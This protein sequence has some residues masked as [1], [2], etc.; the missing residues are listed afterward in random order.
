MTP[1]GPVW[2]R[3]VPLHPG[4]YRYRYVIDGQWQHDPLNADVEPA[5]YGGHNSVFV[6]DESRCE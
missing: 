5:P 1:V 6:L 3:V 4:R 2:S